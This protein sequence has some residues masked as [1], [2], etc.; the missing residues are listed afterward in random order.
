MKIVVGGVIEKDGK[1][2]LVQEAKERCYGKWNIPAG[3]LEIGESI[4]AG[5]I[6]EIKEECGCDVDLTGVL[7]IVNEVTSEH[8]FLAIV[9]STELVAET[10]KFNKDEILDVKWFDKTKIKSMSDNEI[11]GYETCI[12]TLKWYEEGKIYP[13]D[14][15][16]DNIYLR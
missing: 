7:S 11:R 15:F 14:I 10:I 13:L 4:Y 9:F 8:I 2:L 6:R 3:T 5:A 16:N 12:D 1:V